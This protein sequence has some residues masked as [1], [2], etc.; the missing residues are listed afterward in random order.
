MTSK[1]HSSWLVRCLAVGAAAIALAAPSASAA[2]VER[3]LDP[4]GSCETQWD[5]KYRFGHPVSCEEQALAARGVWAPARSATTAATPTEART[6]PGL[7]ALAIRSASTAATAT[8]VGSS[9]PGFDWASAAVG[10]GVAAGLVALAWLAAMAA[11]RRSRLR[12]AR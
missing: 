9:D 8:S 5:A 1:L 7:A 6:F 2:P 4:P 3:F 10:A 12:T 11:S